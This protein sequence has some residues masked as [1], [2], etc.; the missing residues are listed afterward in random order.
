MNGC[1]MGNICIPRMMGNDGEFC[2]GECPLMCDPMT[3]SLCYGEW[4]DKTGC[5]DP[6]FCASSAQE[7]CPANCPVK[8][9]DEYEVLCPGM[10]IPGGPYDGCQGPDMCMSKSMDVNG[11]WC[12]EYS[13]CPVQCGDEEF[14]CPSTFDENGCKYPE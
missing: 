4:N 8:C 10:I 14:L 2:R 11:E 12:P 9:D 5:K 13:V 1:P 6:D 7:G 3:E